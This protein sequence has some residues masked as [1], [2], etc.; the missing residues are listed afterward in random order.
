MR[1]EW[2]RTDTGSIGVAKLKDLQIILLKSVD[3][4]RCALLRHLIGCRDTNECIAYYVAH[5]D[6]ESVD[7]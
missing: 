2:S 5:Y 4:G 7:T 6:F 1:I 3:P